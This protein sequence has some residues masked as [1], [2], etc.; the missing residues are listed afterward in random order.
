MFC[1]FVLKAISDRFVM[2]NGS[3]Q[4]QNGVSCVFLLFLRVFRGVVLDVFKVH[5]L[6]LRSFWD[7][8]LGVE[9]TSPAEDRMV[10]TKNKKSRKRCN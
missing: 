9:T 7:P 2:Q 4:V 5:V 6:S 1:T 8:D 3:I 10:E